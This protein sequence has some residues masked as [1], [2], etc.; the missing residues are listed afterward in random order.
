VRALAAIVLL[1]VIALG[2]AGCARDA[3]QRTVQS[4][5]GTF[6]AALASDDGERACRQLSPDTRAELE[7]QESKPCSEAITQLG[8]DEADVVRADV[9][10][11]EAI[12]ELSDGEAAFLSQGEEGWRISAAGCTSE[13]K[14]ADRPYDC[15]LKD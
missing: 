4:V 14:P 1:P 3:D 13:G 5:A 11:L 15:D 2:T 12:V 8:L 10:V 6:F 7:S 9:Y